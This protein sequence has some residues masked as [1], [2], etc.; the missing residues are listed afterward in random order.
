LVSNKIV[1]YGKFKSTEEINQNEKFS[2][3]FKQSDIN[4]L[5]NK[6]EYVLDN[7]SNL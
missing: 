6:I 2:I 5:A 1:I 3:D 7:I 4:D